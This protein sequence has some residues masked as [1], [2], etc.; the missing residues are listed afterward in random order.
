MRVETIKSTVSME[1][2]AYNVSVSECYF[3]TV[4]V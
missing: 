3:K 1:L 4:L 2:P